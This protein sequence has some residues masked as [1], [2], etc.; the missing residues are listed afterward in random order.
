LLE[1]TRA[2]SRSWRVDTTAGPMNLLP[3]TEI[4]D[5][6]HTTYLRVS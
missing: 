6:R 5:E 2:G 3:F 1:A 4:G